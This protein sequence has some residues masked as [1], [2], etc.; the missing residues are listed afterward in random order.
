MMKKGIVD[1]ADYF[2][3]MHIGIGLP[4]GIFAL[5]SRGYLATTKI[6]AEF[7][8]I[9]AHA[10]ASPVHYSLHVQQH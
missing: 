6:D 2:L 10:A 5:N 8:R 1:D 9:S 4:S 3:G 7:K